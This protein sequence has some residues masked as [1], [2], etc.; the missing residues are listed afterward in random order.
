[1]PLPTIPVELLTAPEAYNGALV[2]GYLGPFEYGGNLYMVANALQPLSPPP[3]PASPLGL[4]D[5]T[6]YIPKSTDRGNTW[7]VPVI[8]TFVDFTGQDGYQPSSGNV[9]SRWSVDSFGQYIYI[10][11]WSLKPAPSTGIPARIQVSRYDMASD[12]WNFAITANGVVGLDRSVA[13]SLRRFTKWCMVLRALPDGNLILF[14]CPSLNGNGWTT[15][16][17]Q[18][19]DTSALTW[20]SLT[21][22]QDDAGANHYPM[23][24]TVGGFIHLFSFSD[25]RTGFPILPATMYHIGINP[26]TLALGTYQ[27]LTTDV[28]NV[29]GNYA[30]GTGAC[31]VVDGV[32]SVVLPRFQS[33]QSSPGRSVSSIFIGDDTL[34]PTWSEEIYPFPDP[35]TS[36]YYADLVLN[37]DSIYSTVYIDGGAVTILVGTIEQP[38]FTGVTATRLWSV[39]RSALGASFTATQLVEILSPG[40]TDPNGQLIIVNPSAEVLSDGIGILFLAYNP[41]AYFDTLFYAQIEYFFGIGAAPPPPPAPATPARTG[42]SKRPIFP[43]ANWFDCCLWFEQ[44]RWEGL[45]IP[46]PCP[47]P[48]CYD[49]GDPNLVFPATGKE[50]FRQQAI[51]LPAEGS[52]NVAVLSFRVPTGYEGIIYGVLHK[53]TGVGFVPGSGTLVWR[54]QLQNRFAKNY[55]NV[56]IELGDF[57][58]YFPIDHYIRVHSQQVITYY[59]NRAAGSGGLDPAGRVI[60]GIRGWFYPLILVPAAAQLKGGGPGNGA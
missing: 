42:G 43:V 20:G 19:L 1:M 29:D 14:Y 39:L 60:T 47:P 11:H 41:E 37:F 6:F 50:F 36:T 28:N 16:G 55:G 52:G 46:R 9:L 31:G 3:P 26:T 24:A 38:P 13:P 21:T 22:I 54:L 59:V 8:T 23:Q 45:E 12:T 4:A 35:S 34:N 18:V 33:S 2:G 44:K 30:T 25:L 58:T 57:S 10:A 7:T 27:T 53:F 32:Q 51:Q 48:M 56:Q 17:C 15:M 5:E 40:E 49:P